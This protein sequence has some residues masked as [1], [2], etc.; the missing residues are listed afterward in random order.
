MPDIVHC[1]LIVSANPL[2]R[3]GLRKYYAAQWGEDV[4]IVGTPSSVDD[5][6]A[7]IEEYHPDLV[8]VDHDDMNIHRSEFMYRFVVGDMPMKVVLVSL[9]SAETV[10]VYDRIKLTAGEADEWLA[11]PW[12]VS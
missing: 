3:D 11:N 9:N 6:L 2:F 8:I 12:K 4:L 7:A 5:A 1:V 10:V